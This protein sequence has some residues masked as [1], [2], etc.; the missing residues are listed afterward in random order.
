MMFIRSP[1][2]H[3][4]RLASSIGYSKLLQR[5]SIPSL[6]RTA[7]YANAFAIIIIILCPEISERMDIAMLHALPLQRAR[8]RMD[9]EIV[10]HTRLQILKYIRNYSSQKVALLSV[11]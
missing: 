6:Q 10:F 3:R 4:L 8:K 5:H 9:P 7:F 11:K 2:A 1:K